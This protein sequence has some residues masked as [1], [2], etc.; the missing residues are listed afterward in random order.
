MLNAAR[1]AGRDVFAMTDRLAE[2]EDVG[3]EYRAGPLTCFDGV[4][5]RGGGTT[6]QFFANSF[7]VFGVGFELYETCRRLEGRG[8]V[9]SGVGLSM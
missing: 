4:E 9:C 8:G 1:E 7:S 5:V 3:I 6:T 2:L